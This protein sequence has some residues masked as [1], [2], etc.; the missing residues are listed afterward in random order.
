MNPICFKHK[1]SGATRVSLTD[2]VEIHRPEQGRTALG[3]SRLKRDARV[4][5]TGWRRDGVYLLNTQGSVRDLIAHPLSGA[6]SG[7]GDSP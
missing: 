6:P 4:S 5:E 7:S 2:T 1:P 3:G